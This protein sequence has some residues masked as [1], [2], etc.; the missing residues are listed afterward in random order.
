MSGVGGLKASFPVHLGRLLLAR[1]KMH[2]AA[3]LAVLPLAACLLCGCHSD[4]EQPRKPRGRED[5]AVA[6][7]GLL[8]HAANLS[9]A[10][11]LLVC[12]D[13][14]WGYSPTRTL[15]G[16]DMELALRVLRE[17]LRDLP[18]TEA[19][20]AYYTKAQAYIVMRF[21]EP[22]GSSGQ[23]DS[24]YVGIHTEWGESGVFELH[25]PGI[26]PKSVPLYV[27]SARKRKVLDQFTK[28]I[29]RLW[30]APEE[31]AKPD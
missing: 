22:G 13:V 23:D 7:E 15:R 26:A 4:R 11:G 8:A 9:R 24:L 17:L 2:R 27:M 5:D 14:T 25:S 31:E 16:Q 18:G 30:E 6:G 10:D 21:Y 20:N 29:E 28:Q 3:S 12:C 1:F 19:G